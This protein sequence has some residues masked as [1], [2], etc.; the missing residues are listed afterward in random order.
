MTTLN[1]ILI[2]ARSTKQIV[3]LVSDSD[4]CFNLKA[5]LQLDVYHSKTGAVI[6]GTK[7]PV[8]VFKTLNQCGGMMLLCDLA[9]FGSV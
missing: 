2:A 6:N 7:F 4:F 3:R 9:P 8:R 1:K 5:W